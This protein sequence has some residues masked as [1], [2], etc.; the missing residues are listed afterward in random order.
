MTLMAVPLVNGEPLPGAL[1]TGDWCMD[2]QEVIV[3]VE[4]TLIPFS[5]LEFPTGSLHHH[6]SALYWKKM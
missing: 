5:V 2:A 1:V 4:V 6:Q 3:W